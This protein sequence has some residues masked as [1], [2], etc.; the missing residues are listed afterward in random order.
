LQ[1]HPG[2]PIYFASDLRLSVR[3][4]K[5]YGEK[6]NWTIV[7]NDNVKEPLHLD[8]ASLGNA[9]YEPYQYYDSFVDLLV[10]GNGYYTV[11]GMAGFKHI[12]QVGDSLCLYPIH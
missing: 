11:E 8:K 6:H 4:V 9:T 7:T 2:D 5:E 12:L 3:T 1:L 10:M